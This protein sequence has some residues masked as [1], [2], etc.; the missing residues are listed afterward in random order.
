M[1]T[2][3]RPVFF[4]FFFPL[5]LNLN[6]TRTRLTAKTANQMIELLLFVAWA[7]A[8]AL[9]DT[10]IFNMSFSDQHACY[11]AYPAWYNSINASSTPHW[12][13]SYPDTPWSSYVPGMMGEGKSSTNVT[14]TGTT[15][16]LNEGTKRRHHHVLVLWRRCMG[17]WILDRRDMAHNS[18]RFCTTGLH[19]PCNL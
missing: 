18:V 6:R 16:A 4:S 7:A 13:T 14:V 9:A 5:F 8:A 19:R 3:M 12:N 15:A 11:F 10:L 2:A 1:Y 17:P